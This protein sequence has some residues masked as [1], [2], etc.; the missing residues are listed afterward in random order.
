MSLVGDLLEGKDEGSWSVTPETTITEALKVLADKDVGVLLVLEG[1]R[2]V[3]IFSERD[4]V[5]KIAS[6]GAVSENTPVKEIMSSEVLYVTPRESIA[7]CMALMT[8]ND[9]R[10]LPVLQGTELVGLISIGDVVKE[11]ISGKNIEIQQ[12]ENY[13]TGLLYGG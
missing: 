2:V 7:E 10:H 1:E 3:G 4:Y 6:Q 5:R 8:S 12:L 11:M 13:I 9:I